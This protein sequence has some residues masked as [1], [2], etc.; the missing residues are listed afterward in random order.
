MVSTLATQSRSASFIASLSVLRTVRDRH[1]GG[2]QH[3][4]PRDVQRL[5][6]GVFLAHVDD[7]FETEQ[8]GG[9]GARDAVLTGAGL[10][11]DALLAHPLGD[12]CLTEYVADLVRTGVVEILALEQEACPGADLGRQPRRVVEL[13]RHAGVVA[14]QPG[15]LDLER[16]VGH[17][18]PVDRVQLVQRLDQRLGNEPSTE[19]TKVSVRTRHETGRRRERG[20][21]ALGRCRRGHRPGLGVAGWLPAVTSSATASRGLFCVTRPSPTSTASAPADAYLMRSCGPRTP[22]S[23]IFTT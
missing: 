1:D 22:D 15:E 4:H 6:P 14:Q 9:G 17:R 13:A 2:A 11:D 19:P 8:G 21:T 20:R 16:L 7:A 5:P 3:L 12:Q 10:G 23:A 18:V